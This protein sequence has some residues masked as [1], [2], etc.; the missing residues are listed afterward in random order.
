RA[1]GVYVFP[2]RDEGTVSRAGPR[3]VLATEA[4]CRMSLSMSD[5]SEPGA[6]RPSF[7]PK[8]V[9]G[10]RTFGSFLLRYKLAQGSMASVYLD[11]AFPPPFAARL[12]ADVAR[13]LHAAHELLDSER[14]PAGLVHRNLTPRN[15]FI[16][17]DGTA[18]VT[19]FGIV[20]STRYRVESTRDD[21]VRMRVA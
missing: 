11:P 8:P 3:G 12:V 21:A 16:L 17:Y 10:R 6:A 1:V 19:D 20:P 13:G 9:E 15:V 5:S 7:D 2:R 4:G 18:K 14:R